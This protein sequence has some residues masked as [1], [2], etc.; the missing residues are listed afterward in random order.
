MKG[1]ERRI[2]NQHESTIVFLL[3][4]TIMCTFLLYVYNTSESFK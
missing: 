3:L 2:S 4:Y 1:R